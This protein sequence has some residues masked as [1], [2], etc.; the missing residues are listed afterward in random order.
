MTPLNVEAP[1]NKLLELFSKVL[2]CFLSL[3]STLLILSWLLDKQ[4]KEGFFPFG[5]EVIT[6]SCS[7]ER[8]DIKR[9]YIIC[10]VWFGYFITCIIWLNPCSSRCCCW[11]QASTLFWMTFFVN[12]T[13]FYYYALLF[14]TVNNM[15]FIMSSGSGLFTT[16]PQRG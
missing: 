4:W 8:W 12:L 14:S 9:G 7:G 6:G 3:L 10:I 15:D 1:P 2:I 5:S 11:F 16:L 13:N